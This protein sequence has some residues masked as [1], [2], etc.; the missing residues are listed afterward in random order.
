MTIVILSLLLVATLTSTI[1]LAAFSATKTATATI[2]FA[3][4]VTIQ[5]TGATLSGSADTH[6][7]SVANNATLNWSIKKGDQTDTTG[8]VTNELGDRNIKLAQI[9]V[10]VKGPVGS[11]T[12]YL[13]IKPTVSW[14]GSSAGTVS[15]TPSSGWT[16]GSD[17]Y[18][19][20]QVSIASADTGVD[21]TFTDA[22]IA[23]FTAGT[24]DPNTWAGRN[25][26]AN[27]VIEANT[28]AIH[29]ASGS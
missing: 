24:D 13:A 23:I 29:V 18:F 26:S 14:S 8:S 1:I 15:I 11:N 9:T 20:K 22:D 19:L 28:S 25:Y 3:N 21:V 2:T 10:N 5:V 27:L 7:T 6:G 12:V 16:E 17:G 4:G